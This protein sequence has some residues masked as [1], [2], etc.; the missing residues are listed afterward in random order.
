MFDLSVQMKGPVFDVTSG[1][2]LFELATPVVG[3]SSFLLVLHEEL[4]LENE[5]FTSQPLPGNK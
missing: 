2:A 4:V 3:S 1:C 5:D